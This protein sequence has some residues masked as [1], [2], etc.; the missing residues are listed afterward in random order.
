MSN[1]ND[2]VIVSAGRTPVGSFSGALS[3]V[4]AH[5]LGAAVVK[6]VLERASVAPEDV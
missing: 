5:D 1:A 4:P 6:G 2:I 3:S